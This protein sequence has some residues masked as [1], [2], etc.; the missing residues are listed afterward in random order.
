MTR[1]V[2]PSTPADAGAIVALLKE[3]GLHPNIEPQHLQ[4]RY[5]R[6]RADWPEPHSFVLADGPDLIAHGGLVPGV[7]LCGARRIRV[8]HV[9][10]WAA[11]PGAVGAG[12]VLMKHIAQQ[13][14]ALLAVGGSAGTLKMLPSLGFRAVGEVRGYACTLHP[15]RLLRGRAGR[16]RLRGLYRLARGVL[17][18]MA[19]PRGWGSDFHFRRLGP[20]QLAGIS[21]AL[22]A[23]RPG[24]GVAERSVTRFEYVLECPIA[25]MALYLL[26]RAGRARGYFLLASTPG[27]VRIAD[28]WM[29][30]EAPEDW[31][32]LIACAVAQAATDPQAA[33]VV[34]WGNDVLTVHALE[35]CGFHAR[36]ANTVQIR[37]AAASVLPVEPLRL[38]MLDSDAAYLN[39]GRPEFWT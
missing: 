12:G 29:D 25:P 22:P 9:I 24:L 14:D 26:E 13:A 11:R 17:R 18:T 35:N 33:E 10:D 15:L 31:R 7:W 23:A 6:P 32:G 1:T 39:D 28:C 3:A 21:A 16:A 4:W 34:G 8:I 37:P 27:Q 2:R 30:S 38:Q 20:G 5:W 36:F 19:A